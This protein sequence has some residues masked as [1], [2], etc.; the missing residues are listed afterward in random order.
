[1]Q[2]RAGKAKLGLGERG[3][4]TSRLCTSGAPVV[5]CFVFTESRP[6]ATPFPKACCWRPRVAWP[7]WV[8]SSVSQFHLLAQGAAPDKAG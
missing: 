6:G 7:A 8:L 4:L 1:M 2:G 3:P 5:T